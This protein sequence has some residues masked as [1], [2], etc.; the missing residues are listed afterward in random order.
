MFIKK[1]ELSVVLTQG[2]IIPSGGLQCNGNTELNEQMGCILGLL[3]CVK[4][5]HLLYLLFFR[6]AYLY[7]GAGAPVIGQVV[8]CFAI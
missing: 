7:C 5:K 2:L 6:G 8:L 1:L 4:I 3:C